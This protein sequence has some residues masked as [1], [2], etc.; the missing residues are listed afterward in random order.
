[1]SAKLKA[2]AMQ[3]SGEGPNIL[4]SVTEVLCVLRMMRQTSPPP[5]LFGP[6]PYRRHATLPAS[7][8][9]SHVCSTRPFQRHKQPSDDRQAFWNSQ[10]CVGGRHLRA[11]MSPLRSHQKRQAAA[12]NIF[13]SPFYLSL[14][15]STCSHSLLTLQHCVLPE[16]TGT[17]HRKIKTKNQ[18]F[19]TRSFFKIPEDSECRGMWVL[20]EAMTRK[21]K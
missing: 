4:S 5:L 15:Q 21:F 2:Q 11:G 1:M 10:K 13:V 19:R 16:T 8:K 3:R 18:S 12:A 7:T 9:S 14:F 6:R 20:P 17:L